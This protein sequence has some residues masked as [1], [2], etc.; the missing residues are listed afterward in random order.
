MPPKDL[1]AEFNPPAASLAPNDPRRKLADAAEATDFDHADAAPTQ[2]L[3]QITWKTVKGFD[4]PMP[5]ITA[6]NGD[7]D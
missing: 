3:D 4:Q 7:D 6:V 5:K 1:V 2:K